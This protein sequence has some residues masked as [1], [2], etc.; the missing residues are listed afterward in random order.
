MAI[1]MG[2]LNIITVWKEGS[3][4]IALFITG[5]NLEVSLLISYLGVAYRELINKTEEKENLE[6]L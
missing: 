5:D 6:D 4:E 2:H 3:T 1:G